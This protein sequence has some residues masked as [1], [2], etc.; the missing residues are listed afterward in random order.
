MNLT[1]EQAEQIAEVEK[2]I[3]YINNSWDFIYEYADFCKGDPEF[4]LTEWK[5]E[6]ENNNEL[7]KTFYMINNFYTKKG[8]VSYF[9]DLEK[10]NKEIDKIYNFRNKFIDKLKLEYEELKEEDEY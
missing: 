4:L 6:I 10:I 9:D 3:K 7:D 5:N 2:T 1:K 8:K